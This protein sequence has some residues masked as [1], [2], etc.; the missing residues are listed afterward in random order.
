MA[1]RAWFDRLKRRQLDEDD[2]Q[3]EIRAVASLHRHTG[4]DH[5]R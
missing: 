5:V 3:E 2:F 1:I 4:I